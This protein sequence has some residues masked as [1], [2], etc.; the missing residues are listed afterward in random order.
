MLTGHSMDEAGF[1]LPWGPLGET[2]GAW[3]GPQGDLRVSRVKGAL[4]RI[5][6]GHAPTHQLKGISDN[7]HQ[8]Q[9]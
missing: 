2:P 3:G 7:T 4:Q 8:G 6:C 9:G 1:Q 5:Q